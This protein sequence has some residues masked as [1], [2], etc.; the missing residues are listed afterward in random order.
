MARTN[1]NIP[2]DVDREMRHEAVDLGLRYPGEFVQHLWK[3]YKKYK[4][5]EKMKEVFIKMREKEFW[6]NE[7]KCGEKM[8]IT[9]VDMAEG[10]FWKSC[11]KY[12][13]GDNN[14]DSFSAS[15][16]PDD[17]GDLYGDFYKALEIIVGNEIDYEGKGE[18]RDW[19][20]N[21]LLNVKSIGELEMNMARLNTNWKNFFVGENCKE[22]QKW[23][24][25]FVADGGNTLLELPLENSD[26]KFARKLGFTEG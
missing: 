18:D 17:D 12:M 15:I 7:C 22:F 25:E 19:L 8:Y 3:Q 5:V 1:M 24:Q 6:Q 21:E 14:H 16:I 2:D 20:T 10:I 23:Y 13:D 9:D 11:P 4:E 26:D